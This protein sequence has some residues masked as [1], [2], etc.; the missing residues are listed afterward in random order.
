MLRKVFVLSCQ[1]RSCIVV[2]M[3]TATPAPHAEHSASTLTAVY[4]M[5]QGPPPA[6]PARVGRYQIG[7]PLGAGAM[8]VV[9]RAH[10]PDLGRDVAIKLVRGNA[11][12]PSNVRLLREAQAMARLHHP[13][14]VPIFDVG[15][16]GD[17]VFVTMPLIEGGTLKR[18]LRGGRRSSGDILD[19]FVAAGRGLAA[20]HAAGL[21]HRD[22][23]PD[24]VLL[25]TGGEIHVADF[26]LAR[27]SD[28]E[29]APEPS[30]G[31]LAPDLT[32]AGVVLGTPAYMAPE[33]LR[34]QPID[35]RADQFSFC[36]ALWEAVYGQRPFPD[37][38]DGAEPPWT[39]RLDAI[40]AG[41]PPPRRDRPAWLAPLLARGMASDPDHRWPTLQA[42]LDAIAVRRRPRR[43][44]LWLAAAG[45]L[46]LAAGSVLSRP[47][48]D[49]APILAPPRRSGPAMARLAP[50]A[51]YDDLKAAA[52]SPDGTK[53]AFVTGDSLVLQELGIEAMDRTVVEHGI[54]PPVAWSP[55]GRHLLVGATP[56]RAPLRQVELVDAGSGA[57][58]PLVGT[59]I[60]AFLSTDEIVVASY[61]QREVAILQIGDPVRPA[62]SCPVPGDYTFLWRVGGLPDGTIVVETVTLDTARHHLVILRRDCT[63]RA[64]FAQEPV[65]SLALTDTGTVIALGDHDGWSEI[66]EISPDG[67]IVSRR[68]VGETVDDVIGRRRGID[69]VTTLAPK[70]ALTRVRRG[71]AQPLWSIDSNASVYVAP[72]GGAVA[73]IARD[74]QTVRPRPLW[75][76]SLPRTSGARVLVD[77]ALTAGWS[78]DGRRLAVLAVDEPVAAPAGAP[79]ASPPVRLLLVTDRSGAVISRLPVDDVDPEAAPVWLDD[80]RIAVRTGDRLT[81]RGVDLVTGDQGAILDRR[82]G[83]TLWLTRS[84]RDG[85]LAM[86]RMGP[87]AAG[88]GSAAGSAAGPAAGPIEH[89]WIQ[90]PGGDPRPLQVDDVRHFLV[91]SWTAAGELV[92][93]TLETGE[94]SRVALDTGELTPIAQLPPTPL[95]SLSDDHLVIPPGG[96]LLAIH[97]ELGANVAKV[98]LEPG[99]A[100]PDA[101][102]P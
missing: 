93:R 51:R 5:G 64:T 77:R 15:Q 98:Q 16:A 45:V 102:E 82:R 92:V 9:Y 60:A 79:G 44:P 48:L 17:A 40:A 39:A 27:L 10:D 8:G 38:P 95:S 21:V 90:P 18:W 13:N 34:C 29:P 26:G 66:V 33:Q 85:T 87:P 74:G 7:E 97:R 68:R 6:G 3:R 1:S 37:P 20:A 42:L 28:Q 80:H 65:S 59:D 69:Y 56:E 14:V 88:A 35:A 63:V 4:D 31:Q 101:G 55:D 86:F 22:F 100:A 70:T 46:G 81:Y 41:P 96:D 36:V 43:W 73:W 99:T 25:G 49:D 47:G 83:S 72:D 61:R 58:R 54:T 62:G 30:D 2:M 67:A 24:N 50:L 91:P 89:L 53:L 23:K 19:R 32:Q 75:L 71:A 94:V 57:R 84:P 52:I 11:A 12:S 76:S 78:P